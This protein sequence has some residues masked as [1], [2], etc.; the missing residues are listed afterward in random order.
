MS[1]RE[2][3]NETAQNAGNETADQAPAV[4]LPNVVPDFVSDLLNEISTGATGL[5]EVIS[6]IASSVN[7][8]DIAAVGVDVAA[9][10]PL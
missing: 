1:P 9:V 6:G 8:A 5:G 7:P 3:A 2:N 4:D 10:I